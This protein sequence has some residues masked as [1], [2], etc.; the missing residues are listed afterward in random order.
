M[1]FTVKA[2]KEAAP[3]PAGSPGS[4][5]T[6][7]P[8]GPFGLMVLFILV[9]WACRQLWRGLG[10]GRRMFS[11]A[12]VAGEEGVSGGTPGLVPG[13]RA[14][15][16]SGSL[17]LPIRGH[18]DDGIPSSSPGR[19]SRTVQP[20]PR[21][22]NYSCWNGLKVPSAERERTEQFVCAWVQPGLSESW[23]WISF[24]SQGWASE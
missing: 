20:L 15:G 17:P 12:A 18:R 3:A 9:S 13:Q 2:R 22:L 11:K 21:T 5:V 14:R 16:S 10:G 7:R 23:P 4:G 1:L 6:L 24:S 19:V 8:A